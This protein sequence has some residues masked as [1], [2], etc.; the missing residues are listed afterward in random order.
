M[1]V[2]RVERGERIYPTVSC[3][4]EGKNKHFTNKFIIHKAVEEFLKAFHKAQ[5]ST[6][7]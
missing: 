6:N 4:Q 1:T 2:K 5:F 7:R 3:D